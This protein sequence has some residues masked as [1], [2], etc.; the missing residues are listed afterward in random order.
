MCSSFDL[1]RV[2]VGLVVI[3]TG[4]FSVTIDLNS[5]PL[6]KAKLLL[7][8]HLSYPVDLINITALLNEFF[9]QSDLIVR[10]WVKRVARH[11][12]VA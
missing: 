8:I 2:I 12:V 4:L 11:H 6:C 7:L 9:D 1:V 3:L 10:L 5:L